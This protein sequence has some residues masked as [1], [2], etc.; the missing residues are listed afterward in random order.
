MT[1]EDVFSHCKEIR[2]IIKK[3]IGLPTSIGIAPTKT[4]AKVAN[5]IAKKI[6]SV[7]FLT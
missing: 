5:D 2:R 4:L 3:W 1:S 7:A 6:A